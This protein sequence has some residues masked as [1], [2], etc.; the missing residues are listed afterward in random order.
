MKKTLSGLVCCALLC[1]G[2]LTPPVSAA[3]VPATESG[4]TDDGVTYTVKYPKIYGILNAEINMDDGVQKLQLPVVASGDAFV[5][6]F[7][8]G[9]T[10]ARC[11]DCDKPY[12]NPDAE[13]SE[14]SPNA[15]GTLYNGPCMHPIMV[16]G[17][18]DINSEDTFEKDVFQWT[19][20]MSGYLSETPNTLLL[21]YEKESIGLRRLASIMIDPDDHF[22]FAPANTRYEP[23]GNNT[24]ASAYGI[25][26]LGYYLRL[27]ESTIKT[28]DFSKT[29]NTKELE[30]LVKP[31]QATATRYQSTAELTNASIAELDFNV[32]T[33]TV[34]NP[35]DNYDSGTVALVLASDMG[36][37]HFVDY[38]LA[39]KESKDYPLRVAG[40][41]GVGYDQFMV[42][43]GKGWGAYLNADIITFESDEDRDTY[44]AAVVYEKNTDWYVEK[45]SGT[46]AHVVICNGQPGDNWLKTYTGIG[47][48]DRPYLDP[49]LSH[50]ICK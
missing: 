48:H 30:M 13:K 35:T 49:A 11:P 32:F 44:R 23:Q 33:L 37:V 24:E 1:T 50:N 36:T 9:L 28:L 26:K 39:P 14:S 5:L 18:Y 42:V 10:C 29:Y 4:R 21:D 25:L 46:D 19:G 3:S 6:T 2:L 22:S 16:D 38:E 31:K 27:P 12:P 7:T 45:G 17:K 15:N 20:N 41:I 43:L 8:G 47:R 34:T 40:H